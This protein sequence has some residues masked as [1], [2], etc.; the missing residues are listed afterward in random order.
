MKSLQKIAVVVLMYTLTIFPVGD[1]FA[2]VY[3]F[4]KIAK[5]IINMLTVSSVLIAENMDVIDTHN[6]KLG[7]PVPED[8]PYS[9]KGINP[10]NF[11]ITIS[12]DFTKRSGVRIKFVDV[13]KDEYGIRN[14]DNLA[15]EWEQVQISKFKGQGLRADAG[16]GEYSRVDERPKEIVYRYFHPLYMN[17]Q[18]LKCHGDP[19]NSPTGD[20]KDITGSYMENYKLGE[21]KG[22]ISM[23]FPVQ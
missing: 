13:G 17:E 4:N 18:C 16:F 3:D 20:G 11:A 14:P 1:C 22:G 12:K 15:D 19:S 6:A 23:T 21:L 5:H 8:E 9:Y 2:Q 10:V 7:M